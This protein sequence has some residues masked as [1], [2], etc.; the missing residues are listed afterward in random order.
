MKQK[1]S[2]NKAVLSRDLGR[3]ARVFDDHDVVYLL[4]A[5][6]DHEGSIIALA[7]RYGIDRTDLSA[8]LNGRKRVSASLA[9]ILGFR[10]VY[11]AESLARD[12][13][14]G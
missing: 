3:Y 8:I 1:R 12:V 2:I 13:S 14:E 7:K 4:R 6:V 10:K 9:K 11:V 5:A